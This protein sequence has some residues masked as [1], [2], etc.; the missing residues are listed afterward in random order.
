[1]RQKMIELKEEIDKS[2]TIVGDL[3]APLSVTDRKSRQKSIR[4]YK[5]QGIL[6]TS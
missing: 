2:E 6:L 5:T 1:M 3:K 4:V